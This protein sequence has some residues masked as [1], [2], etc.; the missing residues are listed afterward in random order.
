MSVIHPCMRSWLYLP[1]TTSKWLVMITVWGLAKRIYS[2]I[3]GYGMTDGFR[4]EN[5]NK[6]KATGYK[7]EAQS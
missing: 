2:I 4:K 5:I 6:I 3:Y 7:G 1:T